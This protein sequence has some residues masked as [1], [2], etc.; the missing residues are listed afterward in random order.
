MKKFYI[1]FYQSNLSNRAC[2]PVYVKVWGD[3]P[4]NDEECEVKKNN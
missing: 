3:K 1:A 2:L 4:Q